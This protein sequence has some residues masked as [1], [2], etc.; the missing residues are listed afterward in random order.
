MRIRLGLVSRRE[1]KLRNT[2]VWWLQALMKIC[3]GYSDTYRNEQTENIQEGMVINI[4]I[5]AR[6]YSTW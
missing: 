4:Q 3:I 6:D 2:M 5:L 1:N